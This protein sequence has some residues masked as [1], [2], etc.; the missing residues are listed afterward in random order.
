MRFWV[1]TRAN[2]RREMEDR[3]RRFDNK[4]RRCAARS[5]MFSRRRFQALP[6]ASTPVVKR[7][8]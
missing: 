4:T 5:L 6:D 2:P 1:D 7:N 3:K 8:K